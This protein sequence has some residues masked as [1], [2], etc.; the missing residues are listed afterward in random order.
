[1][2]T[3]PPF[4]RWLV[5]QEAFAPPPGQLFSVY[6]GWIEAQFPDDVTRPGQS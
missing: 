5:A 4:C 2:A 3:S 6:T 1:V